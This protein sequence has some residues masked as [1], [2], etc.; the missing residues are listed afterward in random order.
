MGRL[1]KVP[2]F[3]RDYSWDNENW[4]DL[5]NDLLISKKDN[6]PHYMGAIVLQSTQDDDNFIVVDGQQRITTMTLFVMAVIKLL[7]Y[8]I[9]Q[10]IEE[11][12]NKVRIEEITRAYIGKTNNSNF[13]L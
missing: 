9:K 6:S 8:L 10:G 12:N 3:Q 2:L 11:E 1:Y 7:E 13:I 5:W 4:E